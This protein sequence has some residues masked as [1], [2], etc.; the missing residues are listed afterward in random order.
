MMAAPLAIVIAE[1]TACRTRALISSPSDPE[2]AE[3][4]VAMVK[5]AKP[6]V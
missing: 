2:K 5:I 1:P 3:S 6:T 4:M